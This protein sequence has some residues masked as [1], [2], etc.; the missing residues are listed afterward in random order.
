MYQERLENIYYAIRYIFFKNS[1]CYTIC[2]RDNNKIVV[3]VPNNVEEDAQFTITFVEELH[4][5]NLEDILYLYQLY[6][7]RCRQ[8]CPLHKYL[9]L[10]FDFNS[11]DSNMISAKRVG[12]DFERNE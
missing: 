1:K 7:Q 9:M 5:I 3:H 6:K 2:T 10:K 11:N 4:I 8:R 12:L